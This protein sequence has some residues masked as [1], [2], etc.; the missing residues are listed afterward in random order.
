MSKH[1]LTKDG[2]FSENFNKMLGTDMPLL[3]IYH[4]NGLY[5]HV[6]KRHPHCLK[7][8]DKLDRIIA[9]PDY[10]GENPKEPNSIELIKHM[11]ENV[12][13]A[14]KLDSVGK[15]YYVASIYNITQSK[16]E[17]R[18]YSGR[19]KKYKNQ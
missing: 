10:I 17:R 4:S 14:V 6:Q 2:E 8:I 7:F 12:M 19:L 9:N 5:A 11:G 16:I 18:L 13:V 3:G 15:Y 1:I